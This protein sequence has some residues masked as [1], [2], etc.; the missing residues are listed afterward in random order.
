MTGPSRLAVDAVDRALLNTVLHSLTTCQL[1]EPQ[2]AEKEPQYTSRVVRP[3]VQ[4]IITGRNAWS[5]IFQVLGNGVPG[6]PS[7][8]VA[9]MEFYPDVVINRVTPR[10]RL[11]A[12][13]VKY[14]GS[15]QSIA[16]ALGQALLYVSGGGYH[17]AVVFLIAPHDFATLDVE[18][19]ESLREVGVEVVVRR[20]SDDPGSL[21]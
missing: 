10:R 4:K 14:A 20:R 13:E 8:S 9:G 3:F 11:L 12:I 1:P 17:L 18:V 5:T 2:H 6:L 15:G 16:T 21:S 7:I 19:I